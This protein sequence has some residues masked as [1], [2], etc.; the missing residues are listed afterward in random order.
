MKK[1]IS[2]ILFLFLEFNCIFGAVTLSN[3]GVKYTLRGNKEVSVKAANKDI[4]NIDIPEFVTIKGFEYPVSEIEARGFEGCKKLKSAVLPNSIKTIGEFAFGNCENLESIVMPDDAQ[5]KIFSG[6]YGY[7][8][9]GIFANCR[10][11]T[12]MRGNN[13]LYPKYMLYEALY[14]CEEVPFYRTVQETGAS[15]MVVMR[16]N[17]SFKNFAT[18]KIKEPVE[19]WQRKKDYETLAQWESRVTNDNRKKMIDESILEARTEYIRTF[20]PKQLKAKLGEYNEEYG[21]FLVD[22]GGLGDLYVSVPQDEALSFIDSWDKVEIEPVYGIVDDNIGILTAKYYLGNNSYDSYTSIEEDNLGDITLNI[23]PLAAVK[24]YEQM[25]ASGKQEIVPFSYFEADMID[26][27]I[28][29]SKSKQENTF[30]VVIGNE[31]YQRVAPVEFAMNDARIFAKYCSRTL[32]I[33]EK[34]IRTYYDATYGD[35]VAAMEDLQNISD[36]FDGDMKVIFYYAGHG[37]PDEG[38]R[39]AYIIPVDATGTQV[40]VCYSLSKLYEQLGKLN[41]KSTIALIDACFSGSLR[42]EG[43]LAS[44]RGIKLK[45]KDIPAEGNLIVLSAATA[46]QSAFPYKEKGHGLFTYYLL[47]KLNESEGEV[48]IGDL[49]DYVITEVSR[50]SVIENQ[51]PQVPIIKVSDYLS[52]NWRDITLK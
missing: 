48:N 34:N 13:V 10:S 30:V 43:M 25:L 2:G 31:N 37:L 21:F 4:I 32:G 18:D 39:N 3:D 41:S 20:A 1:Y 9:K 26:I 14:K 6:N 29:D 15:N 5:V 8:D 16:L 36:A 23:T 44:A 19:S 11:L 38:N 52:E 50:Q 22:A 27:N 35:I 45:P 33:P 24:E 47:K 12:Q 49:S 28:P 46:N 51:K 7:G 42:G 17:R 40:E